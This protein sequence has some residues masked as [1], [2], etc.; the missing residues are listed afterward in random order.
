MHTGRSLG[1]PPHLS[2]SALPCS[3][4]ALCHVYTWQNPAS[5]CTTICIL[6]TTQPGT[7]TVQGLVPCT[8]QQGPWTLHCP[9]WAHPVSCNARLTAGKLHETLLPANGLHHPV[10]AMVTLLG[11]RPG[12][13]GNA[14]ARA[15]SGALQRSVLQHSRSIYCSLSP[16]SR[17]HRSFWP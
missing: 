17:S 2:P 15:G 7:D 3:T 4:P 6:G 14:S 1:A 9:C 11:T 13:I 5:L 8:V 12:I 16:L 10:T